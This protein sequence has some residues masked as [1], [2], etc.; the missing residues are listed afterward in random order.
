MT[1]VVCGM[2]DLAGHAT[3]WTSP[4]PT[5]TYTINA[6]GQT[7]GITSSYSGADWPATLIENVTYTP[8][9]GVSSLQNGCVGCLDLAGHIVARYEE[10]AAK[11]DIPAQFYLGDRELGYY[12]GASSTYT[13]FVHPNVLGSTMMITDHTAAVVNDTIWY[14]FGDFWAET[15]VNGQS[16]AG[17]EQRLASDLDLTPNRLYDYGDYRWLT[18]DPGG[19]K[20]V[21]L[22]DPQTWNMYAYVRNNPTTLTDPSGLKLECDGDQCKQYVAQLAKASGLTL[23]ADKKGVITVAGAPG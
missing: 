5:L 3:S 18:P 19:K 9:G 16:F 11:F 10:P 13:K 20:V 21:H 8:F 2:Y 1:F 7:T 12:G 4:G 15:Q 23:S 6:A 14:P 22:D 17:T